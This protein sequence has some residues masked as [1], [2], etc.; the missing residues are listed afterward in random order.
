[1]NLLFGL[2]FLLAAAGGVR[3]PKTIVA[4]GGGYF[5]V[6]IRLNSGEAMAVVRGG[7]AHMGRAG[8]LDLVTSRDSGKTWSTPQVVV[9]GPEDDRN[10]AIGQLSDG[11]LLVAYV[12]LSGYDPS[13][14]KL[15]SRQRQDWVFDGVYVMRSRDSGK[16]WSRPERSP[17]IHSFYAGKGAVSP[18][19]KIIHLSDDTV[20]MPVYFEFFDERSHQSYVFRSKD[21]GKTWGDP[22]LVAKQA[23]ET[24]L[25]VLPDGRLM[26]A[27]RSEKGGHLLIA[28]SGDKGYTWSEPKQVT[29]DNEHPAD[30][31]VLK[32]GHVVLTYGERNTPMGARALV[33]RDGGTSW[34]QPLVLADDAPNRDCGYPSSV[35]LANGRILTLYYQVDDLSNA[36]RSAKAKAVVWDVSG[37]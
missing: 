29:Q 27:M 23:N 33:S 20:L 10:P 7:G 28:Y 18:Y 6:L 12:I 21:N 22:S 13:G 9:D 26:A 16:T 24:A 34:D 30:L 5:P 35:E 15:A 37:R 36:P 25:A 19:G 11:T 2:T 1:M 14:V 31:I 8:R 17:A 3:G 32:N 4:D